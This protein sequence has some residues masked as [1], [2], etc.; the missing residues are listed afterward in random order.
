M[1]NIKITKEGHFIFSWVL[2]YIMLSLCLSLFYYHKIEKDPIS[3]YSNSNKEW[4]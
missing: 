1:N 2:F 4:S 3:F